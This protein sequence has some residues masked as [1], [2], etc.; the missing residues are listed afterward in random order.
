V[1]V[2]GPQILLV[3]HEI[4]ARE[5]EVRV[6]VKPENLPQLKG[7]TVFLVHPHES[8]GHRAQ[9]QGHAAFKDTPE[10]AG[11]RRSKMVAKIFRIAAMSIGK[12]MGSFQYLRIDR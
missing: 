11:L 12:G 7:H 3:G 2:H 8:V 5:D 9:A 6:V 1:R 4:G 10:L